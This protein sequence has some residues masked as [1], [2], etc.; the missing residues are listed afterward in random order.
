M[1]ASR[2]AGRSKATLILCAVLHTF[3]HAYGVILVPLY[4]LMRD[5]LKLNGIREASLLVSIYGVAYMAC[6]YPAGVLADRSNRAKLLGFGLIA[7][8]LAVA[9]MGVTRRYEL[10]VALAVLGAL[11]GTL[12]HPSA[13]AL[14]PAHFPKNP[15]MAIGMLGIGSGLGFFLGPQYAG[16]RAKTAAWHF[17]SVA[18][19]QKPC[20]ELGLLGA[21]VGIVFL[22]IAREAPGAEHVRGRRPPLDRKLRRRVIATAFVL[23]CRDFSGIASVS[24]V[25]IYLQRAHRMDVQVA[26]FI[27]GSMM[28]IGVVANPIAA[29]LSP[30]RRRLPFLAG[31]LA[32]AGIIVVTVPAWPAA[33]ILT[34]LCAFQACH[35]G[36]YA[37]SDAALL[38]RVPAALRGRV[39]GGFLT[40]AGTFAATGPLVMGY[41]TDRLGP[42]GGLPAAYYPP[43]LLL[44]AMMF[45]AILSTPLLARLGDVEEGTI[46]PLTEIAPATMQPVL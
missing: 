39:V 24:L 9:L 33:W 46:E 45:V 3:T 2:N 42:R 34:V 11:G 15:G 26:G 8:A 22:L 4:F 43:F 19:W 36:S 40:I 28:L 27:V 6:S 37:T 23:G 5:D 35:L 44:G 25:S 21:L 18:Q 13:N 14:I 1:N 31:M 29:W 38:E 17:A 41:W 32:A 10:L 7:N 20:V 12:F 16:W 30:G